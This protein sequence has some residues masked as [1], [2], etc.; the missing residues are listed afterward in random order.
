[1]KLK[2]LIISS[3]LVAAPIFAAPLLPTISMP[4]N[5][6]ETAIGT[7]AAGGSVDLNFTAGDKSVVYVLGSQNAGWVAAPGS[8]ALWI[9]IDPTTGTGANNG[10]YTEDYSVSF[11]IVGFDPNSV[12]ITGV[13]AADD[14]LNNIFVNNLS[15][16]ISASSA[17]TSLHTFTLN[18]GFK[19]G[20]N[21]IDFNFTNTG[22]IGGLLV[23]FTSATAAPEPTSYALA[24]LGLA[25]LGL[26]RKKLS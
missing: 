24:G 4:A 25:G 6:G 12:T 2:S 3:L 11:N 10:H 17:W 13:F 7:A 26:L 20:L 1:L 15:T 18:Q 9:G 14:M 8:S 19:A 23:E 21:T 5:T 22:G 16:G